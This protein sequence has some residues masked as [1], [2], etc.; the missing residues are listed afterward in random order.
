MGVVVFAAAITS[1]SPWNGLFLDADADV[2]G[3]RLGSD[4]IHACGCCGFGFVVSLFLGFYFYFGL[5]VS[6]PVYRE[7]G[8]EELGRMGTRRMGKKRDG[9]R[10]WEKVGG[11]VDCG[12]WR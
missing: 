10:W 5:F 2:A 3:W 7:W 12:R 9:G 8:L 6:P 4:G 11:D 1:S